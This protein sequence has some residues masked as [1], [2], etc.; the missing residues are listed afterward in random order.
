MT[1][2]DHISEQNEESQYLQWLADLTRACKPYQIDTN[3]KSLRVF[4]NSGYSPEDV[5]REI[6]EQGEF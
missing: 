1:Y 3:Q 4:Y 2:F 6:F 5:W